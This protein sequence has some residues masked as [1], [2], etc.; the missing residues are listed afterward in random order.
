GELLSNQRFERLL[1]L[2]SIVKLS[3]VLDAI[4]VDHDHDLELYAEDPHLPLATIAVAENPERGTGVMPGHG[5][6][7]L[8][9]WPLAPS[10]SRS[11]CSLPP[12]PQTRTDAA[13]SSRCVP[14][15]SSA[16]CSFHRLSAKTIRSPSLVSP[17]SRLKYCTLTSSCRAM[18]APMITTRS[19]AHSRS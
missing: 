18:W 17:R 12:S 15:S 10:A 8:C 9:T 6:N 7:S 14:R 5:P 16:C 19:R 3:P 11:R 13:A 4:A 2:G 1:G